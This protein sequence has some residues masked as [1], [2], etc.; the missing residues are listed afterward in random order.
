MP[1]EAEYRAA[2]LFDLAPGAPADRLALLEWLTAQGFTI[3]EMVEAESNS[4][5]YSLAADRALV[6]GREYS[7]EEAAAASGLEPE[8][9]EA[10]LR[11]AG[12]APET[13]RLTE[14]SVRLFR[15]F[16]VARQLFS[17]AEAL[18]FTR[19]MGSALGRIAEA[20][21][22][23]FRVDVV[24]PMMAT[25]SSEFDLAQ[26]GLAAIESLNGVIE[27]LGTLFRLH[28]I[29]ATDRSRRARRDVGESD[30][31]P[32][33]I[34]FIDLVGFTSLTATA[35]PR[36]LLA[37]LL[38]FESRAYD[39]VTDHGGRV[40]K[41]IGDEVMFTAIEAGQAC[42]IALRLFEELGARSEVTPRG[43]IAFGEVLSHGGDYYG[44]IVNLASRVADIA[45]P[46]EILVTDGVADRVTDTYSVAPAGR[47]LLK[48]FD[49][50]VTLSSLVG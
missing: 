24:T 45:V 1:D 11:A 49:E 42:E 39:I 34:G 4:V 31:V 30:L 6:T 20:A 29:D 28:M 2:G 44:P 14:A 43:G 36:E 50:T 12:F 26:K 9:L 41:L 10:I 22:S 25:S 38:E 46:W 8:V 7:R 40:V 35:T 32:M 16:G 23:L 5:L 19:V 47:R 18:H 3:A 27:T 15:E 21:N 37:L 13:A 33:A 48:G 17:D